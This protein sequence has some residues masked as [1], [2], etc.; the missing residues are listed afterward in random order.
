MFGHGANID[1]L[2]DCGSVARP[3][4]PTWILPRFNWTAW[5]SRIASLSVG[6]TRAKPS[7]GTENDH[8]S[9]PDCSKINACMTLRSRTEG[10]PF[11][12]TLR[13]HAAIK[14]R[15]SMEVHCKAMRLLLAAGRIGSAANVHSGTARPTIAVT[16]IGPK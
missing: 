14:V 16:G 12:S 7:P 11:G 4:S 5:A 9:P 10:G 15:R 3:A 8:G 13:A 2:A 1:A 6:N